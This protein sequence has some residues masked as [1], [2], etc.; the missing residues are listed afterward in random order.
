MVKVLHILFYVFKKGISG[1]HIKFDTRSESYIIDPS[2]TLNSTVHD[3]TLC[4]CEL[5]WL[6]G[7]VNSYLKN[8]SGDIHNSTQNNTK[9]TAPTS[10]SAAT[11]GLITQAFGFALQ[12]FEILIIL[13]ILYVNSRKY[14]FI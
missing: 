8:I 6:F 7:R 12:V 1:R 4:I 11:H 3:T 10:A 5:G 9:K 13:I 2:L 14:H